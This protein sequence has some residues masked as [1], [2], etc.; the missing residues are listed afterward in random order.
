MRK[1]KMLDA[2]SMLDDAYVAEAA[3][4][5]SRARKRAWITIAAAAACFGIILGSVGISHLFRRGNEP[6]SI[7]PYEENEYYPL[8]QKLQAFKDTYATDGVMYASDVSLFARVFSNLAPTKNDV[9]EESTD[10]GDTLTTGSQTYEEATDNQVD[11]VIEGD[12]IKRSDR[13][14]Y[15]F[16]KMASRL[17][18]Y[19][20]AG[21]KTEKVGEQVITVADQDSSRYSSR[22]FSWEMYLSQDCRTLTVIAPCVVARENARSR[23][24][25]AVISL[26]VTDPCSIFEKARVTV[27]GEYHS[28]RIVDGKLYLLNR[29]W[30]QSPWEWAKEETFVP[31]I[32]CG[33]GFESLPMEKIV[34]PEEV[35]SP[36][37]TVI[38]CMDEQTLTVEDSLA[39]LS[40][41]D[42]LYASRESMYLVRG[43]SDSKTEKDDRFDTRKTDIL[44]V[45]FANGVLC[46]KQT[47]TVD[48]WVKDQYSLDEYKGILRVVT[49]TRRDHYRTDGKYTSREQT[50]ENASLY[51]IDIESMQTVSSVEH[52]APT[53]ETVQS[54][55]F[56]GDRGYVCT[57]IVQT[58]PV[59]F[60]DLSDIYHITYTDTGTIQGFSSSLI[61]YPNG[62]LLGIGQEGSYTKIEIYTETENA[63]VSLDKYVVR[64]DGNPNYYSSEYKSYLVDRE[65]GLFGFV[66]HTVSGAPTYLVLKIENGRLHKVASMDFAPSGHMLADFRGLHIDGT[67]YVFADGEFAVSTINPS[68]QR[69]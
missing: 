44:R 3:P 54:V 52:F 15:Y 51:A 57:A 13:Y 22:S 59:F 62:I 48:G 39:C 35:T 21:E 38:S 29:F 67:V 49:T 33:N 65:E 31:Q 61:Q 1:K 19:E 56:D 66:Y 6:E 58:D 64:G 10:D 42:D 50:D 34:L 46:A 69:P 45:S 32:D 43:Y 18:V 12:L 60:F 30:V 63:V 20:I 28:S 16:D 14:I 27:A 7:E 5:G 41:V 68:T 4:K 47:A 17:Y 55:R 36:A 37:Y 40:F 25:T 9:A 23:S 2:M 8:M 24:E 53:G 26:D 11:G